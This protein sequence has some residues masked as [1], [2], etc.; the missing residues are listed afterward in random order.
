MP[1]FTNPLLP[2]VELWMDPASPFTT[3]ISQFAVPGF[4]QSVRFLL[5]FP[6]GS[7]VYVAQ[8]VCMLAGGTFA[9]SPGMVINY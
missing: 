6:P 5:A 7:N 2:G 4:D 1:F 8:A 9:G 3:S